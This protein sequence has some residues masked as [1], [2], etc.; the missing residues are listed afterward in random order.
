MEHLPVRH[1]RSESQG[2]KAGAVE[3]VFAEKA[4]QGGGGV[5]ESGVR[6]DGRVPGEV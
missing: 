6:A 2:E 5:L 4:L 1:R 3:Y